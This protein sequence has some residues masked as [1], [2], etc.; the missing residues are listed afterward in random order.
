MNNSIFVRSSSSI[1]KVLTS[2]MILSSE[3]LSCNAS[4][5]NPGLFFIC[6][7]NSF[8]IKDEVEGDE[9]LSPLPLEKKKS[10]G[11]AIG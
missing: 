8:R 7:Q 3:I 4:A 9:E 2:S 10:K 1:Q 11:S 6:Q 5:A